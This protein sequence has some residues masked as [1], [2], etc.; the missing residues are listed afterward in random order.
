[1]PPP[2]YNP[3]ARP[4]VGNESAEQKVQALPPVEQPEHA[5]QLR[6]RRGRHDG[7]RRRPYRQTPSPPPPFAFCPTVPLP[8]RA[9]GPWKP[10]IRPPT[11]RASYWTAAPD[12]ALA[13]PDVE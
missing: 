10:L 1:M 3:V 12:A 8:R 6:D 9:P 7:E 4:A 5:E 11:T 2:L 13:T